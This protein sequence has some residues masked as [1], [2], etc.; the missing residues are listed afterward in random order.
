M[1]LVPPGRHQVGHFSFRKCDG[2]SILAL[3]P[4][5]LIQ[6]TLQ[7]SIHRWTSLRPGSLLP[8]DRYSPSAI[9]CRYLRIGQVQKSGS[10]H[11]RPG[12]PLA[13]HGSG[14]QNTTRAS[15]LPRSKSNQ[16]SIPW[17]RTHN[18]RRKT[19]RKILSSVLPS[20]LPSPKVPGF[21]YARKGRK[22]RFDCEYAKYRPRQHDS[23]R[24]SRIPMSHQ[25]YGCRRRYHGP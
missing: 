24:R 18:R 16:S 4:P 22:Y 14:A 25:A 7:I 17:K 8:P 6:P 12:A 5:V 3:L 20:L 9:N 15:T 2:V 1:R 10:T 21:D 11:R 13:P 23:P 19:G